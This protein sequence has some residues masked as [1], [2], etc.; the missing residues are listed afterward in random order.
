ML[1]IG[2]KI[3]GILCFLY[4][5]CIIIYSGIHASF[6]WFWVI[7]CLVSFLASWILNYIKNHSIVIA[8]PLQIGFFLLFFIGTLSFV[9]IEGT[10]IYYANQEPNIE[11]DYLIILGAQV[12]GDHISKALKL[13][14]D[15]AVGYLLENKK[16]PVIVSGGQGPGENLSEAEAMASYLVL[17]GI[18]K[19]RIIQENQSV[20]TNQNIRFSKKYVKSTDSNIYIVSNGFHIFRAVSIAK[21]QGLPNA[22]GFSAPSDKGLLLSYYIREVFAVVKD[23]LVG[24]I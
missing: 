8:K 23:K 4:S 22:V 5:L 13:R 14:L 2:L 6:L 10:I 21:K 9:I 16:V 3:I 19:E 11:A 12:R 7:V 1:I 24:N 18:E 15:K 20:N 17:C